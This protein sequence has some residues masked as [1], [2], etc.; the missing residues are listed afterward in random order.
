VIALRALE[1]LGHFEFKHF[2]RI[3]RFGLLFCL[4][5]FF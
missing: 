2:A 1:S 5:D 4:H 3:R